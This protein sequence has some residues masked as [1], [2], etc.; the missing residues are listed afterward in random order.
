MADSSAF[1]R[2]THAAGTAIA[3]VLAGLLGGALLVSWVAPL[4]IRLIVALA[5]LTFIAIPRRGRF[6]AAA[7]FLST[8]GLIA[9]SALAFLTERPDAATFFAAGGLTAVGVACA[10]LAVRQGQRRQGTS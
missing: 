5:I 1:S 2:R 3:G 9:L 6:L 10:A 8:G 7:A 4:W